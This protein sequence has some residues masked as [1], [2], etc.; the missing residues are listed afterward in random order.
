M[1]IEKPFT[2]TD[3]DDSI[4]DLTKKDTTE[5]II[6][7]L[8]DKKHLPF[9]TELSFE[10]II[11]ICKLKHIAKK[12]G[13]ENFKNLNSIYPIED[14]INEFIDNFMLHMTSHKRKRVNEFLNGLNSEK[15]ELQKKPNFM[16]KLM[17]DGL[18]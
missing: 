9:I 12:Y 17:G 16:G 2:V 3:I 11:E 6:K 13:K 10:Q 8:L 15:V 1:D 7:T 4:I 5:T 18:K 14:N